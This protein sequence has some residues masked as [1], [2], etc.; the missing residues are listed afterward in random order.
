MHIIKLK[1]QYLENRL[2][3]LWVY[4][5]FYVKM[6]NT[7]LLTTLQIIFNKDK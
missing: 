6:V 3:N 4:C 7:N 2:L 1:G 5:E